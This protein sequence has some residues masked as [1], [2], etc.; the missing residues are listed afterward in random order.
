MI[1]GCLLALSVGLIAG[2]ASAQASTS[3]YCG[4]WKSPQQGCTGAARWLY[5]AYGWGDQSGVCVVIS[6]VTE[7]RCTTRAG[8][9]VY[10]P[11]TSS[12]VWAQPGIQNWS[13]VNNF[14]HGVALTH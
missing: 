8:E 10:S 9:G 11:A 3:E 5:Q 14:V 4:G 1:V 7:W 13:N 2:P 6:G 12:N